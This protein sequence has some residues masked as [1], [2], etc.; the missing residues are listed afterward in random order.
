MGNMSS[1]I[2]PPQPDTAK[3][4]DLR[5]KTVRR[6]AVPTAAAEL[7]LE[8]PGHVI[9]P[10]DG[11]RLSAMKAD[12]SLDGGRV[13]VLVPVCRANGKLSESEMGEIESVCGKKGRRRR[14]S[15]VV[16]EVSGDCGGD[17]VGNLNQCR[18]RQWKPALEPIYEGM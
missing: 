1:C 6:V 8:D 10:L 14:D 7:M 18:V 4:V 5:R 12:E 13:Y 11:F 9:S 3:L 16:P 17:F 2:H 15:K